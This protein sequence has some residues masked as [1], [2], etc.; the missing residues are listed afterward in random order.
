MWKEYRRKRA[1]INTTWEGV[2]FPGPP[3]LTD[4]VSLAQPHTTL[5]VRRPFPSFPCLPPLVPS[6]LFLFLSLSCLLPSIV[7]PSIQSES[8]RTL[9]FGIIPSQLRPHH[10]KSCPALHGMIESG[11]NISEYEHLIR[12]RSANVRKSHIAHKN[13]SGNAPENTS[14]TATHMI[15]RNAN[16]FISA[17]DTT[18]SMR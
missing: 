1:Q 7:A 13:Q 3:H 18:S 9:E 16:V 12:E 10:Q 4:R 6:R 5:S 8:K 15:R 17:H 14:H 2:I 11:S